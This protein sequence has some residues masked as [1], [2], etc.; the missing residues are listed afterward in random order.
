MSP[1]TVPGNFVI[2]SPAANDPLLDLNTQ[3]SLDLQFATSKTLD[4]RVS[5]LPLVDHQRDVSSGKSAGTYVGSDGLIK[6]SKVNL[7]NYSEEFDNA[8]W[9]KS[10]A[11]I[12]PNT[13]TS[14][15]GLNTADKIIWS[16]G[17]TIGGYLAKGSID[18]GTA[19]N[20]IVLYA[21]TGAGT[22]QVVSALPSGSNHDIIYVGNGWYR[23]WLYD[24]TA[25]ETL[26]VYAK[27]GEFDRI[28][29]QFYTSLRYIYARDSVT[30]QGDGTS[31][32]YI[33]GA[34]LEEGSTASPYI[35]TT[36][37]PSA[38]PRFDHDPTTNASLG[39]L[40]EESRTNLVLS[41]IPSAVGDSVWQVNTA[42]GTANAAVA[43][44]GTTTAT[45][46]E[47]NNS[48]NTTKR[49]FIFAVNASTNITRTG[50]VFVKAGTANA[51]FMRGLENSG[52]VT[53]NLVTGAVITNTSS[54]VVT[55]ESYGDGW[56]RISLTVASPNAIIYTALPTGDSGTYYLW[57]AQVE[58]GAFPTSYIP[59]SGSTVTRAADVVSIT[60]SNF[61]RWYE[62]SEGTLFADFIWRKSSNGNYSFPWYIV[63]DA[64]NGVYLGNWGETNQ[65]LGVRYNDPTVLFNV[66]IPNTLEGT[67]CR[68]AT[69]LK[70]NDFA[71]TSNGGAIASYT[72]SLLA[73]N[74]NKLD[75]M[76][77][78]GNYHAIG[79]IS[80]LTYYPYRLPDATLQEITS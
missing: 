46:Y 58:E 68:T 35:K 25:D 49:V 20:P 53:I 15:Y 72:G 50:Y 9:S 19:T 30:T 27:A 36:N 33:W 71:A 5:G 56:W 37:L 42:T 32:V 43:P 29:L 59:T 14:P 55:T 6:T 31:G 64:S 47:I 17:S 45:Q 65:R 38:A 52:A 8:T 63:E 2:Q 18:R 28:Q 10:N 11:S 77:A 48:D 4:D 70:S 74:M 12:D 73:S 62:Q 75:I 78:A 3:P 16:N 41:S 23:C 21:L 79:H 1:T 22:S 26:S 57:G 40:V 7:L 44:D 13:I 66:D 51:L 76:Q 61:S 34:Q 24:S 67:Q 80:R 69:A 60:G 54:S 39:L